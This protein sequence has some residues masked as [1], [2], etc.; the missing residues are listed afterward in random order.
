MKVHIVWNIP[1]MVFPSPGSC[2][3]QNFPT[4]VAPGYVPRDWLWVGVSFSD[5]VIKWVFIVIVVFFFFFPS[6][7]SPRA[8]GNF[9]TRDW[10][11]APTVATPDPLTHRPRPGDQTHTSA[12]ARATAVGFLTHCAMAGIPVYIF[13]IC[14]SLPESVFCENRDFGCLFLCHAPTA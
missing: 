5:H 1:E 10:I 6:V 7:N 11:Q 8:Y 2:L 13:I 4:T 12:V 14:L 9:W 3:N